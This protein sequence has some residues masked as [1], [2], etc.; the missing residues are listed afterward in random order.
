MELLINMF[1]H[2]SAECDEVARSGLWKS[3]DSEDFDD[4]GQI[5]GEMKK[6]CDDLDT[7]YAMNE[8]VATKF[9]NMVQ[10]ALSMVNVPMHETDGEDMYVSSDATPFR[11]NDTPDQLIME[12]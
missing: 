1:T 9:R 4:L 2:L 10:R 6:Q 3:S 12:Q 11:I 7:G 5:F 8:T